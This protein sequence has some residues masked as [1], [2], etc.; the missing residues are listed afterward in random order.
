MMSA[1]RTGNA[2]R[3]ETPRGIFEA[4]YLINAAGSW[5]GDVARRAGLEAQVPVQPVGRLE[6]MTRPTPLQRRDPSSVW[7]F[8][9]CLPRPARQ[10]PL[11]CRSSSTVPPGV[12]EG[13]Y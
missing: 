5:A 13:I 12:S 3:V 4:E 2:W 9:R 8:K 6:F 1:T 11:L 7:L 10:R